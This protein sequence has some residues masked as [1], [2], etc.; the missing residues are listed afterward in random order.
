MQYIPK[1][2]KIPDNWDSWFTK[3]T[4][5][6]SFDYGKD[7]SALTNLVEAKKY[8]IAEQHGLCAYC[9]TAINTDNASIEHVVPKEKN[10][11][12]S[13]NYHNLVAVCKSQVKDIYTGK[14]HCDKE[15]ANQLI[16]PFIFT[17]DSDVTAARNNSYFAAYSDGTISAKP[18]LTVE[19]GNEADSFINILNLNHITLKQRRTKDVLNGLIEASTVV[20]NHQKRIFWKLQFEKILLNKKQPY[21]QYLLIYIAN[22]LGI[23]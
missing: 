14:M 16:T 17:N 11:E 3:A 5:E 23:N 7:Y 20:P 12:L 22:K 2:N 19:I 8:L 6:R 10:L 21:R 15:K 1:N 9:Q 4:G 13:T 18:K